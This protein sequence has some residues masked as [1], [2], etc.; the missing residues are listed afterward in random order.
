MN[1]YEYAPLVLFVYNRPMHVKKNLK[2]LNMLR[3]RDY[4]SFQMH[5][6]VKL[7]KQLWMK[8]VII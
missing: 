6:K 2:L 3:T 1:D 4:L 7:I 8:F 5:Q